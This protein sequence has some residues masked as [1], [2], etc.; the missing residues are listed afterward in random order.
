MCQR[1]DSGLWQRASKKLAHYN[2]LQGPESY[3]QP[4][5]PGSGSFPTELSD[6][7][8][9]LADTLIATLQRTK[10]SCTGTPDLWKQSEK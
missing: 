8:P 4:R 2:S 3:Q 10:L 5:E 6:R 1:T 9:P 7:I